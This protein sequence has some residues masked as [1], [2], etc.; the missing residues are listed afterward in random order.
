M[1]HLSHTASAPIASHSRSPPNECHR[2][3]CSERPGATRLAAQLLSSQPPSGG[4][5][6]PSVSAGHAAGGHRY[7][8]CVPACIEGHI[9]ARV[10]L[11]VSSAVADVCARSSCSEPITRALT[12]L[13]ALGFRPALPGLPLVQGT[14][15]DP[16]VK[17]NPIPV[18]TVQ[19]LQADRAQGRLAPCPGTLLLLRLSC[20]SAFTPRRVTYSPTMIQRTGE[21]VISVTSVTALGQWAAKGP[22][23]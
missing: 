9:P 7:L 4:F 19:A 20:H 12:T 15:V 21:S 23:R 13:L 22:V 8:S 2:G 1:R 16:A 6:L 14:I 18:Q 17:P 10:R 11:P 5:C 3:G